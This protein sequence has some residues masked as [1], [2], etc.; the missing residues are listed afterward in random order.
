MIQRLKKAWAVLRNK[1]RL[2]ETIYVYPAE[3][4]TNKF[5]QLVPWRDSVLALDAE[6]KI[7]SLTAPYNDGYFVNQ[8]IQESP[9]RY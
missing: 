8:F 6:G 1:T 3:H 5:V 9:R 2:P 7:W 4:N